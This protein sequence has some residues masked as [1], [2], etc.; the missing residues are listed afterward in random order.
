MNI[1]MKCFK[2]GKMKKI[3]PWT[4]QKAWEEKQAKVAEEADGKGYTNPFL[5]I[6]N[7]HYE[8]IKND[9]FILGQDKL[10]IPTMTVPKDKLSAQFPPTG[11]YSAPV[12]GSS[13]LSGRNISKVG[14][15]R[16]P[17][18]RTVGDDLDVYIFDGGE[19]GD[20]DKDLRL[21]QGISPYLYGDWVNGS[22]KAFEQ[23]PICCRP[24]D[25]V[26]IGF[27]HDKFACKVCGK[28]M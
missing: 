9:Q 16:S 7:R 4:G 19:D 23:K 26:N 28:D 14:N 24:E 21:P 22:D 3:K 11:L 8:K 6:M 12:V 2:R 17:G 20:R 27:A 25:K 18:T 15:N 5:D 13:P 10:L 1:R